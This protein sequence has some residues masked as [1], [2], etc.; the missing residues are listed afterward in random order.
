MSMMHRLRIYHALLA[1]LVIAAYISGEWGTIHLW[2]GYGIAVVIIL[3]LLFAFAGAPQLGLARFYPQF[4]DLKLDSIFTSPIISR[5]LLLGIAVCLIGVTLTGFGLDGGRGLGIAQSQ[6]ASSAYADDD[7]EHGKRRGDREEN[8]VL[9][10]AHE[11][12][13]NLLMLLVAGHVTYLLAFKRPI[14]RFMLFVEPKNA[15]KN[16]ER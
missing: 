11:L 12:F 16:T 14:A 3:R 10:E 7:D 2:L 4:T 8:K 1:A 6:I 13:S 5:S 15:S 9:E